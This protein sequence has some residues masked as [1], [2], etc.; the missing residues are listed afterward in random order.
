ML[1]HV[2][3]VNPGKP[4]IAMILWTACATICKAMNL[5]SKQCIRCKHYDVCKVVRER[6]MRRYIKITT[7]TFSLVDACGEFKHGQKVSKRNA[8]LHMPHADCHS[9]MRCKVE[10]FEDICSCFIRS[11]VSQTYASVV[12][13]PH[14]AF[15]MMSILENDILSVLEFVQR[16]HR[17]RHL[18]AEVQPPVTSLDLKF[19]INEQHIAGSKAPI[20]QSNVKLCESDVWYERMESFSHYPDLPLVKK[21]RRLLW[22]GTR[23]EPPPPDVLANFER[24]KERHRIRRNG[25]RVSALVELAKPFVSLDTQLKIVRVFAAK[26]HITHFDHLFTISLWEFI[27]VRL[28]TLLQTI[29]TIMNHSVLV[30]LDER[31]GTIFH[32]I[33]REGSSEDSDTSEDSDSGGDSSEDSDSEDS[34]SEDSYSSEGTSYSDSSDDSDSDHGPGEHFTSLS[35]SPTLDCCRQALGVLGI[36]MYT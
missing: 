36:P 7:P 15:L 31:D 16:L 21:Q 20:C 18:D 23:A 10:C 1:Q 26:A 30:Q 9:Q 24:K 14:V 19:A 35:L 12:L 22:Q 27:L 5:A 17:F 11:A 28:A 13:K 2:L 3:T 32:D 29:D 33:D 6:F 34:D 8:R 4:H 25:Q